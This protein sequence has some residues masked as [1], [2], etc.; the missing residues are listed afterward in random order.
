MSE[1]SRLEFGVDEDI[2]VSTAPDVVVHATLR[3][4]W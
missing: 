1:R 4:S 2:H 3:W